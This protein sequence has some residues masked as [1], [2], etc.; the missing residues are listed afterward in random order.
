[1]EPDK[2]KRR[3]KKEG[4][5][6]INK[7]L[8]DIG[9][10]EGPQ[11]QAV[12]EVA[13]RLRKQEQ[14]KKREEDEMERK[15][16]ANKIK[17]A[18]IKLGSDTEVDFGVGE[19][20]TRAKV[21]E[22]VKL[23][24][25]YRRLYNVNILPPPTTYDKAYP[26]VAGILE[27]ILKYSPESSKDR[28]T[29][30]EILDDYYEA[31]ETGPPKGPT[32]KTWNEVNAGLADVIVFDNLQDITPPELL[33]NLIDQV[34]GVEKIQE[35]IKEKEETFESRS[36]T[37]P[38]EIP[39]VIDDVPKKKGKF[40]EV[41]EAVIEKP[42]GSEFSFGKRKITE[43]GVTKFVKTEET[44]VEGAVDTGTSKGLEFDLSKPESVTQEGTEPFI[45]NVPS[46]AVLI[47][48][49]ARS[50]GEGFANKLVNDP[51][52]K[53]RIT[54]LAN[55]FDS[56]QLLS[57]V[58]AGAELTKNEKGEKD[59]DKVNNYYLEK[60]K[61]ASSLIDKL[62]KALKSV[63]VFVNEFKKKEQD[64][65][66]KKKMF[67][68]ANLLTKRLNNASRSIQSDFRILASRE[69]REDANSRENIIMQRRFSKLFDN[70][71]NLATAKV[72]PKVANIYESQITGVDVLPKLSDE[73]AVYNFSKDIPAAT[74]PTP[75]PSPEKVVTPS[76]SASPEKVVQASASPP[77][78]SS[79]S[80]TRPSPEQA[81]TPVPS[82]SPEKVITPE[83]TNFTWPSKSV[84]N[85]ADILPE[86][87]PVFRPI[88]VITSTHSAS[89]G[90]PVLSGVVGATGFDT[91]SMHAILNRP[92]QPS[93]LNVDPAQSLQQA[94]QN[95]G[96]S[97]EDVQK[98]SKIELEKY[99]TELEKERM[100]IISNQRTQNQLNA[101]DRTEEMN[102]KRAELRRSEMN[103]KAAK[104]R[105]QF[106]L[107][108]EKKQ[109]EIKQAHDIKAHQQYVKGLDTSSTTMLKGE[110]TRKTLTEKE[111]QKRHAQDITG[112]AGLHVKM[113]GLKSKQTILEAKEKKILGSLSEQAAIEKEKNE[114]KEAQIEWKRQAEEQKNEFQRMLD[115]QKRQHALELEQ[116]KHKQLLAAQDQK[117]KDRLKKEE[118][119]LRKER[120]A[121][122]KKQQ[123][124]E[125]KRKKAEASERSKKEQKEKEAAM[126]LE[127]DYFAAHT[128]LQADLPEWA[129]SVL[130]EYEKA[131][132]GDKTAF[133][134]K[135]ILIRARAEIKRKE[136]ESKKFKKLEKESKQ[137]ATSTTTQKQTINTKY[138]SAMV[139]A[140]RN[141]YDEMDNYIIPQEDRERLAKWLHESPPPDP[142]QVVQAQTNLITHG[143]PKVDKTKSKFGASGP[144]S[145]KPISS[146]NVE[147]VGEVQPNTFKTWLKGHLDI[148]NQKLK[149]LQA[150]NEP[151]D[152]L[153]EAFI[154]EQL[155]Y[156]KSNLD[157]YK[158]AEHDNHNKE[159]NIIDSN[160][161][162][163]QGEQKKELEKLKLEQQ[164]QHKIWEIDFK[165]VMEELAQQ[166]KREKRAH[167]LHIKEVERLNK[168]TKD[169]EQRKHE[170][171]KE[172]LKAKTKLEIQREK[173]KLFQSKATEKEKERQAKLI[174]KEKKA[175]LAI[176]LKDLELEHKEETELEKLKLKNQYKIQ[177]IEAK[178]RQD[179]NK[180]AMQFRQ[181]EFAQAQ[182]QLKQAEA[183]GMKE[184][185]KKKEVA[186]EPKRSQE[187]EDMTT[188]L[189][190]IV[191]QAF[192]SDTPE[193]FF[194]E[195]YKSARR[196]VSEEKDLY[197]LA[198][199]GKN[200]P[201]GASQ[202]SIAEIRYVRSPN[203]AGEL[204]RALAKFVTDSAT[205]QEWDKKTKE[206]LKRAVAG[207]SDKDVLWVM[208][209][210][211][212]AKGAV[213][214][215]NLKKFK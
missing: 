1:M 108:A 124:E 92:D 155:L 191:Q 210:G 151:T 213:R 129:P 100:N 123:E 131:K 154:K 113:K 143:Y 180:Q 90:V 88:P 204:S 52:A 133:L 159:M 126:K 16:L 58:A 146:I 198:G 2:P 142:D 51:I 202:L 86:S 42:Q 200:K 117:E 136:E 118:K 215:K 75:Q 37:V 130:E 163:A 76:S 96:I 197:I 157:V 19:R 165:T 148:E 40:E 211:E 33:K 201:K 9:T 55:L 99:K 60:K 115:E 193:E 25:E 44:P 160:L 179:V 206:Q 177:E 138:Q 47:E 4:N 7:L 185:P 149:N 23:R 189:K 69:P 128:L 156:I 169:T 140:V 38:E 183:R 106:D 41:P 190:R 79:G 85:P 45:I 104:K 194:D 172:K 73:K 63:D 161:K 164:N 54:K 43:E 62:G 145:G 139:K 196:F 35:R 71:Y 53:K 94:Q 70:H 112:R 122:E 152:R 12:R 72:D 50:D 21:R 103:Y 208:A 48:Y 82:S 203:P 80:S 5:E 93:S 178:G 77:S 171:E 46:E 20:R 125:K 67:T 91:E 158:Q 102:E 61:K 97:P 10:G 209:L 114:L 89:Q 174:E 150:L 186:G 64:P 26:K 170:F 68:F 17:E 141:L 65:D 36:A 121:I 11:E 137:E 15:A 153:Q 13:E 22:L 176:K 14:D 205:Y 173:N 49:F 168:Q 81:I 32:L 109:E 207:G 78:S 18:W 98:M 132:R 95:L 105:V 3:K 212:E 187:A 29:Y 195:V 34:G 101:L 28:E 166:E 110:E 199:F 57:A 182:R 83:S 111:E 30:R 135:D 87:E 184:Q 84:T 6:E 162:Y 56:G 144:P 24:K 31:T 66:V 175:E 8:R 214:I 74:V 39:L 59:P 167:E 134:P 188:V 147:G 27:P 192:K 120:E 127:S 116:E 181:R 107:G 119:Q